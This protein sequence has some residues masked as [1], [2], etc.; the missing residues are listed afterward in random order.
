MDVVKFN[1]S[2]SRIGYID[3]LRF[4]GI[5]AMVMGHIGFYGIFDKWIHI[6]HMPLFFIVAGFFYKDQGFFPMLKKRV[7]TLL[8]PY[9]FFG[10]FHCVFS[11]IISKQIDLHAIY[12]FLWENTA[13]KGIPIAGALW[14]LPA[15]FFS[16][17]MFWLVQR[18]K[19][20]P[21]LRTIVIAFISIIGMAS[22]TYLP[23]RLPWALD[24]AMVGVGLYG[25]G[26]LIKDNYDKLL[27]MKS[28]HC[29]TGILLFSLLG[30]LDLKVN[31]RTG[32][33]GIWPLFWVDAV[34]LTVSLWG[35]ARYVYEWLNKKKTLSWFTQYVLSI[36]RDSIVYLC[37]NQFVI[38]TSNLIINS[39]G[40][41]VYSVDFINKIL[42]LIL[43][44]AQLYV[45]QKILLETRLKVIFGK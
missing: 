26:K 35:L 42:I 39:L 2:P 10:V 37:L 30:L 8:I 32:E 25:V 7:R 24:A 41:S 38:L 22:A 27:H 44:L 36:G 13:E 19:S 11:F 16:E 18:L 6:F 12:L 29:I 31:L 20:F 1:K 4:F 33:Y 40:F 28:I 43:S 3:F 14:F 34:G 17:H 15:I 23:F 9:L 5:L 21:K 45:I